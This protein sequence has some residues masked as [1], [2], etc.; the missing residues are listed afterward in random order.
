MI[1]SELNIVKMYR[2]SYLDVSFSLTVKFI[3]NIS[4]VILALKM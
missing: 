1:F 4:A 2:N 3:G